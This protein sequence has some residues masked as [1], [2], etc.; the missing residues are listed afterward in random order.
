VD[1]SSVAGKAFDAACALVPNSNGKSGFDKLSVVHALDP[2]EDDKKPFHLKSLQVVSTYETNLIRARRMYD[3]AGPKKLEAELLKKEFRST[4]E[5]VPLS[6]LSY[7]KTVAGTE[8]APPI[9]ACLLKAAHEELHPKFLFMGSFGVSGKK[10]GAM[11]TIADCLVRLA[12][13]NLVIVKHWRPV[14]KAKEPFHFVVAYDG[15]PAAKSSLLQALELVKPSD[16]LV[17]VCVSA[18][19][20]P[21]ESEKKALEEADL[22]IAASR[23]LPKPGCNSLFY[24]MTEGE[25]AVGEQLTHAADELEADFLVIGSSNVA[26]GA[27]NRENMCHL[28]SVALYCSVHSKSHTIIIKPGTDDLNKAQNSSFEEPILP[29]ASPK[30]RQGGLHDGGSTPKPSATDSIEDMTND[31]S[32]DLADEPSEHFTVERQRRQEAIQKMTARIKKLLKDLG[33]EAAKLHKDSTVDQK[34]LKDHKWNLSLESIN[35]L[36]SRLLELKTTSSKRMEWRSKL[37]KVISDFLIKIKGNNKD[38]PKIEAEYP[39]LL[40]E[41]LKGLE[42]KQNSLMNELG[43]VL[44]KDFQNILSELK[45]TMHKMRVP[46]REVRKKIKG[47]EAQPPTEEHLNMLKSLAEKEAKVLAGMQTCLTLIGKREQIHKLLAEHKEKSEKE[48][49]KKA[50]SQADLRRE[51]LLRNSK[52]KDLPEAAEKLRVEIKKFER[53]F[54]R[55]LTIDGHIYSETLEQ[56][57]K[58]RVQEL[59]EEKAAKDAAKAA[60]EA[61]RKEASNAHAGFQ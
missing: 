54:G 58:Q 47:W 7:Y 36:R 50:R 40:P 12:N 52:T 31:L 29:S 25:G 57:E 61:A 4:D 21:D 48:G 28:G 46:D 53:K 10:I 32:H 33:I 9:I 6:S 17:A 30:M 16:T 35:L 38:L 8:H 43:I 49:S 18:N 45:T 24:S 13:T 34:V 23:H 11:G 27:Q 14:P 39:G 5:M 3:A 37:L 41:S 1:G 59:E 42:D 55:V 22:L 56:E 60:K 2:I 15:S 44:K 26:H 20:F 51:E 19:D